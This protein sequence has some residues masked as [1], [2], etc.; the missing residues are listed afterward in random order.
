MSPDNWLATETVEGVMTRI[1]VREV[2][3]GID[4]PRPI[5]VARI[6]GPYLEGVHNFKPGEHLI[7]IKTMRRDPPEDQE[8]GI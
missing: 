8:E 5:L 2:H 6:E 4:D 3:Y 1:E 7:V